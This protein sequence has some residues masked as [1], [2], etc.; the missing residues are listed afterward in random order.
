MYDPSAAGTLRL[1]RLVEEVVQKSLGWDRSLP[2]P[3]R[4]RFGLANTTFV[5][6]A[7]ADFVIP[8]LRP[9]SAVMLV[10]TN[11][12]TFRAGLLQ[13]RRRRFGLPVLYTTIVAATLASGQ[14]FASALM[15]WLF[16]FWQGRLRLEM[17]E[18]RRRVL[19]ECLPVPRL[20]RLIVRDGGEILVPVDWLRS[21][22]RFVVGPGEPV[23]ADGRVIE[24]EA[25]V[26][27]RSVRGLEGASRRRRGDNLLAGSTVLAGTLSVEV[28][29][30]PEQTRA[31]SIGRS[32]V[33]AT[34]PAAGTL[35]PTLLRRG[36]CRPHRRADLGDRR[37][38]PPGRRPG[39][40][41]GDPPP[42]LRDR[43][44][45]LRCRSRPFETPP[46][47]LAEGSWPAL[48]TSSIAWPAST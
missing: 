48:P 24:G 23:P 9:V 4:T 40:R 46:S 11:I 13:I 33:A 14:Y 15:S 31:S 25:I 21:S 18:G 47:V 44:S 8:A 30:P 10:A 27:E 37:L 36:V 6:A 19:E 3:Q 22:D 38:R 35:T 26:D 39:S 45:D 5:I 2:E 29:R 12:R 28:S 34:S 20:A 42:R 41:R 1:V 32:L 17:A 7:L 43:P 16:R